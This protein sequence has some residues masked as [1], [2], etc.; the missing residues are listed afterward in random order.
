MKIRIKKA[1]LQTT[2]QDM[3]RFNYLSQGVPFSGAMDKLSAQIANRV[4]GN[5]INCAVIEFT[6]SG[7]S[8]YVEEDLLAAFSGDGVFVSDDGRRLP[9]NGP[10]FLP[11]GNTISIGHNKS[12]CRSYMAVAGGWD[13]PPV[14]GSRSTYLTAKIGGFEGRCLK[15][16]DV[17]SSTGV[18]NPLNLAVYESLKAADINY[19][20]WAIARNTFLPKDRN[21]IRVTR[22][23]EFDWFELSSTT[24]FFSQN[25]TVGLN[26]NRMGYHLQGAVMARKQQGELLSTA[27]MPGTI[28]V[29]NEGSMILLMADAQTTG[30]YPRIAQ[31]AAVD[32]PLCAQLKPGDQISFKEI[33][34]KEAETLLLKQWA[35]LEKVSI[36]IKLKYA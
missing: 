24:D 6:Q 29:T 21:T 9:S 13:V 15:E 3:G 12:G 33:G 1:G 8:F 23:R 20:N 22:G 27:V 5:D 18:L 26:S 2:V 36:A 32:M 30:G 31:V 14:L 25:F 19:P 28:Q 4:L 16:N 17:L 34:L 10:V 7:A 35:D 11:A